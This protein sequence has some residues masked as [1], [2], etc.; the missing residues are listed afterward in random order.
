MDKVLVP[1]GGETQR[2]VVDSG[3]QGETNA[4]RYSSEL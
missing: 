4:V 2:N 3:T 1:G